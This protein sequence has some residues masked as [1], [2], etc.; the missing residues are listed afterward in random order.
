MMLLGIKTLS[1]KIRN[2]LSRG[3]SI[4]SPDSRPPPAPDPPHGWFVTYTAPSQR[5]HHGLL[6][7]S[8]P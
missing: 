8:K 1:L 7:A 2:D 5:E 4:C 6:A 3:R